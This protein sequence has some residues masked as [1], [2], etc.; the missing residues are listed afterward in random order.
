MWVPIAE[1]F[2][3]SISDEI[4]LGA[5]YAKRLAAK[6]AVGQLKEP[7]QIFGY[8]SKPDYTFKISTP[9]WESTVTNNSDGFRGHELD[10]AA[11]KRVMWL[12]DSYI[13]AVQVDIEKSAAYLLSESLKKDG[14]DIVV[15]NLGMGS[16]SAVQYFN[17]VRVFGK[18]YR[19]DVI[20]ITLFYNDPSGDI[21]RHNKSDVIRNSEGFVTQLG[22]AP[23][24]EEVPFTDRFFLTCIPKDIISQMQKTKS[25]PLDAEY[26]GLMDKTEENVRILAAYLGEIKEIAD[27]LDATLVLSAL[28]FINQIGP[29][30][31][32]LGYHTTGTVLKKF[33]E[34]LHWPNIIRD[35]STEND[36]LYVD[37]LSGLRAHKDKQLFFKIDG[38]FNEEGNKRFADIFHNFLTSK[39]VLDS[40]GVRLI[41]TIKNSKYHIYLYN[42]N[43]YA[44]PSYLAKVDFSLNDIEK[45]S[46]VIKR[47]SLSEIEQEIYGISSREITLYGKKE[48]F[49]PPILVKTIKDRSINIVMYNNFFY[50]IPWSLGK[51]DYSKIS[52][53]EGLIKAESEEEVIYLINNPAKK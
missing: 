1:L 18:Q 39:K 51:I 19:P 36:I 26:Y 50:G 29:G 12:G 14:H 35:F 27:D 13:Q 16:W 42:D 33:E 46:G 28:P 43:Y 47:S 8:T 25:L 31:V 52:T 48:F 53:L 38:H 2:L 23:I 21:L 6:F 44:L 4:N 20:I 9:E 11:D 5:C 7:H 37:I 40:S 22:A 45:N 3:I 24:E 49:A 15:N 34:R 32:E 17:A 10:L 30:Q 41:K